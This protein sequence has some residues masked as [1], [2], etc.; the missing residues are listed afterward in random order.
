MNEPKFTPGPWYISEYETR[1]RMAIVD[2]Q[3]ECYDSRHTIATVCKANGHEAANAALIAAA[4]ELYA[5]LERLQKS[6]TCGNATWQI[7]E[8]VLCKARGE[9]QE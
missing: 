8:S 4:P 6:H 7:I 9:V 2:K 3:L 5:T 1:Q